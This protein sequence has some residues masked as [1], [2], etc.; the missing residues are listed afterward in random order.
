MPDRKKTAGRKVHFC[1]EYVLDPDLVDDGIDNIEMGW[2]GKPFY[3]KGPYNNY[4][5]I[6]SALN[7]SVGPGG[8]E[9]IAE[10]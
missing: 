5:K 8:Y 2:N 6:I 3:I 9:Y 1:K 4:R 10:G 7:A